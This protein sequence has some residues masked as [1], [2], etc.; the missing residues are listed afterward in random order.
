MFRLNK[1]FDNKGVFYKILHNCKR[2]L[3]KFYTPQIVVLSA[4][5]SSSILFG[6]VIGTFISG[7]LLTFDILSFRLYIRTVCGACMCSLPISWYL[8]VLRD[9]IN[10]RRNS[11]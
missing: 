3:H 11:R 7:I 1:I 6:I 4:I 2:I 8:I 9:K 10:K 5:I